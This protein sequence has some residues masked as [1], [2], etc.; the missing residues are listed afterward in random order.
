MTTNYRNIPQIW[1]QKTIPVV[2]RE[3]KSVPLMVRLPYAQN[4]RS[5]L[6]ANH[7]KS[8]EWIHKY[9]YWKMPNSWFDDVITRL[10]HRFGHVYV[11]Q[12]F[13]TQEKCAPA[14]WRANGFECECS[15]MGQHHGSQN[16]FG[17]WR[18]ISDT[19]AVRWRDRELACRLIDVTDPN[20]AGA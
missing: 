10:L 9:R 5:W 3:G 11:I 20:N 14:C 19:F 16:P 12:P 13:R 17:R 4:N 8:P 18:V 15:C 2:Y 1:H 6:K 7:R